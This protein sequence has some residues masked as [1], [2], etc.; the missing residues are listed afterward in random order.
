M[1]IP[2]M[3]TAQELLEFDVIGDDRFRARHNLDNYA[4]A[5]FGGQ[6]LGQALAAAQRTVPD[7][8]A[9]ALNGLFLRAGA[10]AKP[11]DFA[12]E[13]VH[14]GRNFAARRV[15]ASQDGKAIFDLHCSF[16]AGNSPSLRHQFADFGDPPQPETL[17]NVQAFAAAYA[18]RL[19]A[20]RAALFARP[21]P[22]ELR[23]LE[24][25]LYFARPGPQTRDFWCRVPSAAG[26]ERMQ[27]HQ[28][29][30]AILSDYW[31][32]GI[33]GMPHAGH[34]ALR[35]TLSL[36][37]SLWFHRTA[38]VDQWLLYRTETQWADEGRGL[39]RGLIFDRDGQLVASVMQEA[40]LP[41][42]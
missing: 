22:I 34:P 4:G 2:E 24:P 17:I 35:S 9:H 31:F 28:A 3:P 23:L 19:P 33:I 20:G 8:P 26:L 40:F 16:H 13:R 6:A 12:V 39:A 27:D 29:L 30:L 25:E 7:W 1:T 36:N 41:L 37:E 10:I 32:P 42:S 5:T 14:D 18:E 11:I 21:F 15:L 38:R